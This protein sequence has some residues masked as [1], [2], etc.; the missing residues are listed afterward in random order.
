MIANLLAETKVVNLAISH[1]GFKS[2]EIKD[3]KGDAQMVKRE[4]LLRWGKKSPKNT[5]EV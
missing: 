3:I 2:D 5:P 1:L 4:I